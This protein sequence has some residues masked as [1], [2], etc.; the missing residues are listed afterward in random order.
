[1][2]QSLVV[3]LYTWVSADPSLSW[4]TTALAEAGL[5]LLPLALALLWLWPSPSQPRR[6]HAVLASVLAGVL[7]VMLV[8]VLEHLFSRPRPFIALGIVPLFPHA[9]DSSFP[10]D[11]ALIGF[12]LALPILWRVPRLGL[13]LTLWALLLGIARVAAA[14]HYPID[15]LGSAL[16]ALIP[17][18]IG[19][20]LE[21]ILLARLPFLPSRD[22]SAWF[23]PARSAG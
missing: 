9:A 8:L 6:R 7:A 17:G 3:T 19:L 13:W 2:D 10:S 23:P 4:T 5:F 22:P 14:V 12:A 11:H 21:P 1:V 15:I 18:A 20:S 16:I